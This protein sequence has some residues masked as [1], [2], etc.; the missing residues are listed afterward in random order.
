MSTEKEYADYSAEEEIPEDEALRAIAALAE[1]QLELEEDI[2][3]AQDALKKLE[4]LHR[5]ISQD[6][7]PAAMAEVGMRE[8]TMDNGKKISITDDWKASIS[9]GKKPFV[10]NWLRENEHDDIIKTNVIAE[11]SKGEE[12][13]AKALLDSL[14]ESGYLARRDSN[15]NTSTFKALCKELVGEGVDLPLGDLGIYIVRKSVIK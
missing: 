2:A 10:I 5:I 7:L 6:K 11:F 3:T 12:D 15:V 8:F 14:D 4:G 1:E 9:G 13:K